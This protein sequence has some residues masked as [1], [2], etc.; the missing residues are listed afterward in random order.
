MVGDESVSLSSV[1][2]RPPTNCL[3]RN[4]ASLLLTELCSSKERGANK[5][6]INKHIAT[7]A[8]PILSH[9]FSAEFGLEIL[10]EIGKVGSVAM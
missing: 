5:E 7:E 9:L 6:K 3:V 4:Q 2:I 1:I 8:E 10:L